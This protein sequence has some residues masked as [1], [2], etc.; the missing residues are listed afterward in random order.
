MEDELATW[1]DEQEF[2][3]KFPE[4][5]AWGQAGGKEGG[6]VRNLPDEKADD[7][8]EDLPDE[9]IS[10]EQNASPLKPRRSKRG[11]KP[12]SK[13]IGPDWTR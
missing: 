1:E 12:S 8:G 13:Y 6:N 9:K 2:K 5:P 4:A 10:R 11:P 7:E 3:A